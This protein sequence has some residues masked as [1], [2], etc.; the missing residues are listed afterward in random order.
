MATL[1]RV[2]LRFS[3]S[4]LMSSRKRFS[5]VGFSGKA[6][7]VALAALAL[8]PFAVGSAQ[9]VGEVGEAPVHNCSTV[10]FFRL[11]RIFR[12][13]FSSR[14]PR[15]VP[16]FPGSFSEASAPPGVVPPAT[17][18]SSAELGGLVGLVGP[19]LLPSSGGMI[20][21]SLHGRWSSSSI[22]TPLSV[23]QLS[24]SSSH[25]SVDR[26]LLLSSTES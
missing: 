5:L 13:S 17:P 14:N 26:P 18:R 6:G 10:M 15:G 9:D 3:C 1:S 22:V 20:K 25:S 7:V 2:F 16:S 12:A 23:S 8:A 4:F 24:L 19:P 11:S 21:V